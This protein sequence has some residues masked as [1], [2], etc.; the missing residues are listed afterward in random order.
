M[1]APRLSRQ[2]TRIELT[3]D[4]RLG[5]ADDLD[6]GV[7]ARN[8]QPAVTVGVAAEPLGRNPGAR[9]QQPLKPRGTSDVPI[10]TRGV[11]EL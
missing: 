7:G 4:P 1:P 8:R 5:D 9:G 10:T 3:D 11:S 6:D 2:R